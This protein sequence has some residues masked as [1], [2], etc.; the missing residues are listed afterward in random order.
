MIDEGVP[1]HVFTIHTVHSIH[2]SSVI[3]LNGQ[4]KDEAVFLFT[5]VA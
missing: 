4:T 3:K 1:I 2:H 5:A